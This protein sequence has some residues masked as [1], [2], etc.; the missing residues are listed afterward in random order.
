MLLLRSIFISSFIICIC[1]NGFANYA[2]NL[3]ENESS[4][5][6]DTIVVILKKDN[7][8]I[9]GILIK[10]TS[11]ALVVLLGNEE[12]TFLKN[13][14]QG[15]RF[16]TSN[17][18][19]S[20]TQF[21]TPNYNYTRYCFFPS[22]FTTK[23]GESASYS[24]YLTTANLKVGITDNWEF[25]IG[26]I[27]INSILTSV[28]YSKPVYK[29]VRLAVSGYGGYVFYL[30]SNPG[31]NQSGVGII[32]RI[33]FGDEN[34]NVSMGFI[35]SKTSLINQW[36]YGSY[37]GA[38]QKLKE[39]LTLSGEFSGLTIDAHNILLL[40]DVTLNFTT[41]RGFE[42]ISFGALGI[43]TNNQSFIGISLPRP[44]IPL[45]YLGYQRIF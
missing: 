31:T 28:S 27:F 13:D 40:G 10:E 24:H 17:E 43:N 39:R 11:S 16:I 29:S 35:A 25:S 41:R 37:L 14:I 5:V 9:R 1:S 2:Y 42:V 30:P 34:Q 22:S 38:Q 7:S 21:E 3:N 36:V 18:I 20:K 32:P 19:K 33:S 45:P 15:Y 6:S 8:E 4:F 23:R 12:I 44:F 26:S